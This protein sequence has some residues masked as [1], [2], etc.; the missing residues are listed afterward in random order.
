MH[1]AGGR[2]G[3]GGQPAAGDHPSMLSNSRGATC[4]GCSTSCRAS[5]LPALHH[6]S[7]GLALSWH[8][9]RFSPLHRIQTALPARAAAALCD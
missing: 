2:G 4:S 7:V 6:P 8:A 1:A 5:H 3:G 9:C